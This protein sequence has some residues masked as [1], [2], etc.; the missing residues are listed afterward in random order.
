MADASGAAGGAG[1]ASTSSPRLV[2]AYCWVEHRIFELTGAWA[3]APGDAAAERAR[4]RAR[5]GTRVWCA[6]V[7]GR[8]GGAGGAAGPSGCRCGRGSTAPPWWPRRT[9]HWPARSMRS[10]AEAGPGGGGGRPG[11]DPPAPAAR[12]LRWPTCGWPRPGQRGPGPGGPDGSPAA[13]GGGDPGRA[14]P[15][16]RGSGTSARAGHPVRDAFRTGV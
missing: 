5:G 7:S 16:W 11:R 1:G 3:S 2:G 13:G 6:A 9:G 8:H 14:A 4:G 15:S 10:A 12:H